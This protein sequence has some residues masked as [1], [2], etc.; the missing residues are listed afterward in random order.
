[1]PAF[2][3]VRNATLDPTA[4][5]QPTQLQAAAATPTQVDL[6]FVRS[7]DNVAVT[8]YRLLRDGVDIGTVNPG[9]TTYTDRTAPPAT[10]LHYALQ[11]EDGAGNLSPLSDEAVATTPQ[12]VSAARP[13]AHGDDFA[14]WSPAGSASQPV[15]QSQDGELVL[16]LDGAA[17]APG[18]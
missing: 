5:T 3:V 2:A 12:A 15:T 8:G 4:P 10:T 18:D 1:T 7:T 17:Y 13:Y 16:Q 6:R 9:A 11:A 14:Q